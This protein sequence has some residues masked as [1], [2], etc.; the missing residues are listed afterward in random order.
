M[1]MIMIIYELND[2]IG[3]NKKTS[4]NEKRPERKR[5]EDLR[6]ILG[7]NESEPESP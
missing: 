7:W 6:T 3:K 2:L 1:I 5:G 4:G